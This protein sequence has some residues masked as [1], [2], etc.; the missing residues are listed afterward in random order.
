MNLV[1]LK[2]SL[3]DVLGPLDALQLPNKAF[4]E[5]RPHQFSL[6]KEPP[7]SG[8]SKCFSSGC[9]T[10]NNALVHLKTSPV[11]ILGPLDPLQL[12]NKAFGPFRPHQYSSTKEPP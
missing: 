4:G 12:P 7:G 11:D 2:T 9:L 3:V 10:S 1:H 8:K 5:F 6:T